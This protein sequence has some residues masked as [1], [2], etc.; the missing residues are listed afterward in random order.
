MVGLEWKANEQESMTDPLL[1]PLQAREHRE[2]GG[3]LVDI[4]K[5]GNTRRTAP[6][7]VVF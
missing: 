5:A 3:V 2:I 4:A 6:R 1:A 7:P